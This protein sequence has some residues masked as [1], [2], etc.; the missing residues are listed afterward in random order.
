MHSF[1]SHR[2]ITRMQWLITYSWIMLNSCKPRTTLISKR[3]IKMWDFLYKPSIW[4][5]YSCWLYK[6]CGCVHIVST[7]LKNVNYIIF[8]AFAANR[9]LGCVNK[10]NRF[11]HICFFLLIGLTQFIRNKCICSMKKMFNSLHLLILP[12]AVMP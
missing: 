5:W 7:K 11:S 12:Y 9:L 4:H 3:K 8:A 2:Y 10:N 1:L 6:R